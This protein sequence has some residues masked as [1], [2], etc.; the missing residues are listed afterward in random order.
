MQQLCDRFIQV[1][2]PTS[3]SSRGKLS[4]LQWICT[5]A[6]RKGGI[7]Q[8]S[9]HPLQ[10]QFQKGTAHSL[11]KDK[12]FTDSD[13]D[14]WVGRAGVYFSSSSSFRTSCLEK[15]PALQTFRH[16]LICPQQSPGCWSLWPEKQKALMPGTEAVAV[17]CCDWSNDAQVT[18]IQP[19]HS[20]NFWVMRHANSWPKQARS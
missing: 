15:A 11:S 9:S 17:T 19:P 16:W 6:M 5:P 1:A 7:S 12:Y 18:Q 10:K 20:L 2:S 14:S 4:I 13:S 3:A 8:F